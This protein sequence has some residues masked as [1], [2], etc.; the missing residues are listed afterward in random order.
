MIP[1][2]AIEISRE[3][4]A[5]LSRLDSPITD[6]SAQSVAG[7]LVRSVGMQL[8]DLELLLS[9]TIDRSIPNLASGLDLDDLV[10]QFGLVRKV[11]TPATGFV[12]ITVDDSTFT[13][14]PGFILTQS[15]TGLQFIVNTTSAIQVSASTEVPV[16]VVSLQTGDPSNLT[17]GTLL[18]S[19]DN[20]LTN[21]FNLRA[22]VGQE[23]KFDGKACGNL[24]G[25]SSTETDGTLRNRLY[26]M[27]NLRNPGS[28]VAIRQKLLEQSSVADAWVETIA[29][30]IVK[31]LV[32]G[33][34]VL[35]VSQLDEL[36]ALI[37]PQVP[38][39]IVIG[40]SAVNPYFIDIDLAITLRFTQDLSSADLQIR[41]IISTYVNSLS[42]GAA[43]VPEALKLLVKPFVQSVVVNNP[44]TFVKPNL[45][46]NIETRSIKLS[47][48][49]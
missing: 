15:S 43:F 17:E 10:A 4:A 32:R 23:R 42:L 39:G 18:L 24:S 8:S 38:I 26:N 5:N 40:L 33:K 48:L 47:Y 34:S 16:P 49:T 12:L 36:K 29:P 1:R 30:G 13:I 3:I 9:E 21:I 11:G 35:T 2:T 20:S 44:T 46:T 22:V 45:D 14:N 37:T 27:F 6:F 7:T 41:D 31:I 19:T 25:G 28:V